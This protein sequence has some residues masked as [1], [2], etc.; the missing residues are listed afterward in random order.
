MKKKLGI[1]YLLWF[2]LGFLGAHRLY[3]GYKKTGLAFLLTTAIAIVNIYP[4]TLG[5]FFLVPVFLFWFCDLLYV[6]FLYEEVKTN[7][8]KE[9]WTVAYAIPVVASILILYLPISGIIGFCGSE[10]RF[11]SK[12]DLVCRAVE[13]ALVDESEMADRIR[14]RIDQGFLSSDYA[15]LKRDSYDS[16]EDFLLSHPDCCEINKRPIEPS[17]T[18][19]KFPFVHKKYI[20]V[21]MRV[22]DLNGEEWRSD[23]M[24]FFYLMSSCGEA[25]NFHDLN[26]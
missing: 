7:Q 10:F 2:F 21:P 19:F 5:L 1:A 12:E 9:N 18:G 20:D 22:Y 6:Q 24:P 23:T 4:T 13:E 14:V 8:K 3:L 16:V 26:D 25:L 17:W 11:L 15:S